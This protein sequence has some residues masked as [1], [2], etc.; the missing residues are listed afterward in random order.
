MK[1]LF[2]GFLATGFMTLSSFGT[3]DSSNKTNTKLV[4]EDEVVCCTAYGGGYAVTYCG[5]YPCTN[6]K[7]ALKKIMQ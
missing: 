4:I 6:A 7:A 5:A 2:V 3:F 1:N